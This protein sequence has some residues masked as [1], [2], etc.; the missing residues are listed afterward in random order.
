MAATA[1]VASNVTLVDT[2]SLFHAG[3]AIAEF[4]GDKLRVAPRYDAL[5]R[6]LDR[7]RL[8]ENWPR[9]TVNVALAAI[10]PANQQQQRFV[11]A[12]RHAG[13]DV[14]VVSFWD[15][16]PSTPPSFSRPDADARRTVSFAPRIAYIAGLLARHPAASLLVVSHAFELYGPLLDLSHRTQG[17][18]VGVA[19]FRALLEP[20]WQKVEA[21]TEGVNNDSLKF[22]NLDQHSQDIFGISLDKSHDTTMEARASFTRF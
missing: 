4:S 5:R 11:D 9:S 1:H 6:C 12:V 3:E 21:L 17:H 15:A 19:Y 13:F 16:F 18:N 8:E 10:D 14:D 20:R 7:C 22:F 2:S